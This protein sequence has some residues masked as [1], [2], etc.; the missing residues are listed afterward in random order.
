MAKLDIDPVIVD[1]LDCARFAPSG[2]NAQPWKFEIVKK[3]NIILHFYRD[4][5]NFYEQLSYS[6]YITAGTLLK[7]IEIAASKHGL[8]YKITSIQ[9]ISSKI[10]I[11]IEFSKQGYDSNVISNKHSLYEFI[12]TRTCNRGKYKLKKIKFQSKDY[13]EQIFKDNFTIM[14]K[15]TFLERLKASNLVMK[16]TKYRMCSKL[17]F[18][19]NKRI[20]SWDKE[21]SIDK[22]PVQGLPLTYLSKKIIKFL[23]YH[24][25]LYWI[26][27]KIGGYIMPQIELDLI[28]AIFSS[29]FFIIFS[30]K[31]EKDMKIDDW[32]ILGKQIQ[33]FWLI[34]TSENL[35]IQPLYVPIAFNNYYL[36]K[37]NPDKSNKFE[38]VS[39]EIHD[40]LDG[41]CQS[42]YP[43]FMG[44]IGYAKENR[45]RS[46]R[47]PLESL[48]II[49]QGKEQIDR[50]Y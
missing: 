29:S 19:V 45:C 11:M 27:Q 8:E 23:L 25:K 37:I 18:E 20:L 5:N 49:N 22:I 21:D 30:N 17:A 24:E 42:K 38:K 34:A 39:S 9:E 32:L 15:D 46:L 7:N 31:S 28:P 12:K 35:F 26:M 10:L 6:L 48:I 4:Q 47:K 41:I 16:S 3:H 40:C 50:D 36:N 13:L 14:W 2:D 1:I 43:V 33:E 44:R